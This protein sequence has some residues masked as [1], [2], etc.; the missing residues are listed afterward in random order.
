MTMQF[1]ERVQIQETFG[2]PVA[3]FFG[4]SVKIYNFSGVCL[5]YATMRGKTYEAE[6]YHATSLMSL[7]NN[8]MRGTQLIKTNSEAIMQVMNHTI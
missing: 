5:E 1:K 2:A 8:H 4:E 3:S 6:Y 7:Y